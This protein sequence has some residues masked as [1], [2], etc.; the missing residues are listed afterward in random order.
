VKN[1]TLAVS[2]FL[3]LFCLSASG[4]VFAQTSASDG[5]PRR[6]R[7]DYRRQ[8]AASPDLK[9][10]KLKTLD[11]SGNRLEPSEKLKRLFRTADAGLYDSLSFGLDLVRLRTAYRKLGFYNFQVDSI[12]KVFSDDTSDV[13]IKI[14]LTEGREF[15][16]SRLTFSGNKRFRTTDLQDLMLTQIGNVMDDSQFEKDI[17]ELIKAYESVGYAFVRIRIASLELVPTGDSLMAA[18]QTDEGPFVRIAGFQIAGNT[19]TKEDVITRELSLKRGQ[20]FNAEKFAN[21][22]TQLD[23]LGYFGKVLEPELVINKP[24][25]DTTIRRDTIEA[26]VKITVEE[27]NTSNFDGIA[28]YQP[29][30]AQNATGY[31]TG[32]VNISLRNTFGTGRRIDLKWQKPDQYSQ[33]IYFRYEEP[34]ILGLPI[35]LAFELSQVKQDTTYTTFKTGFEA[36]YRLAENLYFT[37]SYSS[38]QIDPIYGE[39]TQNPEQP[40]LSSKT[41]LSGFGFKVDTRDYPISPTSGLLLKNDYHIGKKTVSASDSLVALY[42]LQRIVTVQ[43]VLL[44]GEIYRQTFR[45]QVLAI[46][47]H[48]KLLVA[49]QIDFTDFFGLGGEATLR[50]YREKQF[51]GS[52]VAWANTEYRFLL[53]RKSFAFLFYDEGYYYRPRDI[54]NPTDVNTQAFKSGFGFGFNVESPLGILSVSYALGQGDSP[55]QGKVHFGIRSDF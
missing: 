39:G 52:R 47:F 13:R 53:S 10:S 26:I 3:L 46:G 51:A 14:F 55:F 22:K 30:N 21:I 45:K 48:A 9:I 1:K 54:F 8:P 23:R 18:V 44:D 2:I 19:D 49:E 31:F 40:V 32:L 34:W 27:G 24:A 33:N 6:T 29:A 38:E 16:L 17:D 41:T 43:Q 12:R 42:G 7:A 50:G 11:F 37:A 36:S 35:N 25:S 15:K 20:P 5:K 4:G 28:G